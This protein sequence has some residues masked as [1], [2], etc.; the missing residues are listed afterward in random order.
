MPSLLFV[1][2][3]SPLHA[4]TGHAN[5][6]V[7]RKAVGQPTAGIAGDGVIVG[8]APLS[9]GQLRRAAHRSDDG[10]TLV[11]HCLDHSARRIGARRR[12]RAGRRKR[13]GG[14]G[15]CLNRVG[16]A[17]R[18]CIGYLNALPGGKT[19]KKRTLLMRSSVTST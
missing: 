13:E 16:A 8:A 4:G 2:A 9:K 10:Q 11:G 1:H 15:K 6:R 17:V 19:T 12:Q 7:A 18:A 3:L 14:A 5:Q